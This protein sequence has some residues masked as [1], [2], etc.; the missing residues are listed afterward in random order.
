MCHMP[1]CVNTCAGAEPLQKDSTGSR[2]KIVIQTG[3][4][5]TNVALSVDTVATNK[6]FCKPK[7]WGINS[8]QKPVYLYLHLTHLDNW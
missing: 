3:R 1:T 6:L 8:L 4:I 7:I 5:A 2:N